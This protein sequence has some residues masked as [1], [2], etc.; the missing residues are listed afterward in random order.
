MNTSVSSASQIP[1]TPAHDSGRVPPG[2][3]VVN[4]KWKRTELIKI[5]QEKLP[6]IFEDGLGVVDFHPSGDVAVIYLPETDLVAGT[7]YRRKLVKLHKA[8]KMRGIVLMERTPM[9]EQYLSD[10]QT[11]GVIN[12]GLVLLFVASQ[13]EAASLLIQMVNEQYKPQ[14]NPF[15]VMRRGQ[16]V[17]ASVQATVQLIPKLGAV[18][19]NALLQR[20]GSIEAIARA[21]PEELTEVVGKASANNIRTFFEFNTKPKR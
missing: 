2:S 3:L 4:P 12:L 9:T 10:I 15:R 18:K 20:F 11:F 7:A 14:S 8:G 1:S 21:S 16:S 6:L 13:T 5:L 17:D 19:A